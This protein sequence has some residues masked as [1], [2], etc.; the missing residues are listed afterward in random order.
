[1][2]PPEIL[3]PTTPLSQLEHSTTGWLKRYYTTIRSLYR[4]EG[5]RCPGL[6]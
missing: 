6:V 4:H 1:M 2:V 3:K 5:M